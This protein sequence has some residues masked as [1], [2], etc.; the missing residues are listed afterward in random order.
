MFIQTFNYKPPS[1]HQNQKEKLK[2]KNK[3]WPYGYV[4]KFIHEAKNKVQKQ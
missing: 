1:G 2:K 4:L 3:I